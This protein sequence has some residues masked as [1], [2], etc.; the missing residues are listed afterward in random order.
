MGVDV[1]LADDV[2]GERCEKVK[3]ARR[4][5]GRLPGKREKQLKLLRS[6]TSVARR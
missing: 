5:M 6:V 4:S 1:V 2:W 3:P